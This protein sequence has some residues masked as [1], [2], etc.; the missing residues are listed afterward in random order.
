MMQPQLCK[1]GYPL[2][3]AKG[4]REVWGVMATV[5]DPTADARITLIDS[6][7]FNITEDAVGLKKIIIDVKAPATAGVAGVLFQTPIK[8]IDGV[9]LVDCSTN[10][11]AGRTLL[12]IS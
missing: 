11:I 3:I 5:S 2:P 1:G 8:V 10:L 6:G 4:K 9:C 12:Y 7:D